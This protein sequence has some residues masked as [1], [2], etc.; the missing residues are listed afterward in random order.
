MNITEL[1]NVL[2]MNEVVK[3]PRRGEV[4]GWR[5]RRVGGSSC[6]ARSRKA[7]ERNDGQPLNL[8][9]KKTWNGVCASERANPGIAR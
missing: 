6:M 4:W 7:C 3:G 8:D 2:F 5:R 1:W 9:M